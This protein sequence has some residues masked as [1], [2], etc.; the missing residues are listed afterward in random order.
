MKK[1]LATC[2]L[3]LIVTFLLAVP[4]FA[5]DIQVVV[6]GDAVTFS[7]QT[8]VIVDGRTLVPIRDVFEAMGFDI[9]WNSETRVVTLERADDV[10]LITIDSDT[11][12]ANDES[13][14]L[15]VP[16][17]IIGGRTMLP[18]RAVLESVG[19]ELDWDG[20]TQTVIITS[21]EADDEV[22]E[23]DIDENGEAEAGTFRRGNAEFGF[24]TIPGIGFTFFHPEFEAAGIEHIGVANMDG[25]TVILANHGYA[26]TGL[27]VEARILEASLSIMIQNAENIVKIDEFRIIGFEGY[28]KIA[29]FT[30]HDTLLYTWAFYDDDN[31]VRIIT[32]AGPYSDE[33]KEAA[34]MIEETFSFDE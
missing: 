1:L 6:N 10:V 14:E 12:T 32:L 33:V 2:T 17:Q 4:I 18:L 21:A 16:A 15:D 23:E 29:H 8:P 7:D 26:T 28:L 24:I 13:F 5:N 25:I 9:D 22:D 3:A 20:E 30:A 27:E 19:Y 34:R 11:F 31:N